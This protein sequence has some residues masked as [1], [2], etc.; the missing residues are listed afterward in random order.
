MTCE[1]AGRAVPT[2]LGDLGIDRAELD[3]HIAWDIGAA[4]LALSLSR[5]LDA[6]LVLQRYT[7]LAIDCNR[8]LD[9]PDV[10]PAFSDGT[11]IPVNAELSDRHRDARY[12]EIHQPFHDAVIET[13]ERKGAA[14]ISPVLVSVHSFT[15]VLAGVA[16]AW[17]LGLLYNRDDRLARLFHDILDRREEGVNF[18]HNEPYSVSDGTDYT[19]PVHGEG[20]GLMHLL[21]E[22][23][24]D[25]LT[26]AAGQR[27][28]ATTLAAVLAEIEALLADEEGV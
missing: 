3:R 14:G 25:H 4:E 20:R 6:P 8:P 21:L 5:R 24:N 9:A 28:W 15:P 13:L 17:D 10:I 26:A 16:R 7:R 1:H 27:S 18:A 12:R 2:S 23:R 22:V 11:E 19:I